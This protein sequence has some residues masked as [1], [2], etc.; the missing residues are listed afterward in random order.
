MLI[1]LYFSLILKWFARIIK[2]GRDLTVDDPDYKFH[3][4]RIKCKKLR[5]LLEFFG[6]LYPETLI[7][8]AVKQLKKLQ[9]NLG[10]FNDYSVQIETLNLMLNRSVKQPMNFVKTV[11]GLI[12]VLDYKMHQLKNEFYGLLEEFSSPENVRLYNNI[13]GNVK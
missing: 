11:A 4:L 3:E 5:Y 12:T 2:Y 9:E 8:K 6:P 7:D 13:F 10:E 1:L